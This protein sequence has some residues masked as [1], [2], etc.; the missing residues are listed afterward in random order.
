MKT[1][2]HILALNRLSALIGRYNALPD[3]IIER[4]DEAFER[5]EKWIDEAYF[6]ICETEKVT[7]QQ[8]QNIKAWEGAMSMWE[9]IVRAH[10]EETSA[11]AGKESQMAEPKKK[12]KKKAAKKKGQVGKETDKRTEKD[13]AREKMEDDI[14][15]EARSLVPE[16]ISAAMKGKNVGLTVKVSLKPNKKKGGF[17][18]TVS[19]GTSAKAAERDRIEI[20]NQTVMY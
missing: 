9:R 7:E 12:A 17:D 19:G 18:Y 10:D 5:W 13:V 3:W 15:A 16:A 14:I 2:P 1:P 8:K 11:E 4:L 20:S 6:S